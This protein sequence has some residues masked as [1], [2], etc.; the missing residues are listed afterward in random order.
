MN[1]MRFTAPTVV[2]MMVAVLLTGCAD[3]GIRGPDQDERDGWSRVI[4]TAIRALPGVV[5]AKHW[6]LHYRDGKYNSQLDVQLEDDA[7]PAEAAAVVSVMGAQQLPSRYRGD[8]TEVNLDR[9]TDSYS[10]SW[11]FGGDV[12]WEASTADTWVRVSAPGTGTEV[13][14]WARGSMDPKSNAIIVRAGSEAEP[15]RAT[16]AMR[17]IIQ[18]FP[19]LASNDWTVSPV[20]ESGSHNHSSLTPAWNPRLTPANRH[21]RFPSNSELEL[22]EWFLTDQPTPFFV[23]LIVYDPPG[24]AG[25]TLDVAIYPPVGKDFT[26]AQT[27]Q[28]ADRHLPRLAQ[29]GAV[30]EYAIHPHNAP[31]FRVFAG[32]CE[33]SWYEVSPES[34]PYA[35]QYERC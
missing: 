23:E 29:P 7:T 3:E 14:W 28:L 34:Q 32:G 5:T 1:V 18:D 13:H 8:P 33:A 21:V 20:H 27:T 2:L 35:R 26:A 22:W 25:R 31:T 12:G 10:A 24:A 4:E 11:P 9:M 6:F 30:V 17:R 16:A 19:E 15:R